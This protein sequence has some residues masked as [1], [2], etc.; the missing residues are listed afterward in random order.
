MRTLLAVGLGCLLDLLLGDPLWMPH[1]VRWIGRWIAWMEQVLRRRFPDTPEGLRMAGGFLAVG[2]VLPAG[3]VCWGTLLLADGIHPLAGL[4]LEAWICCQCLAARSL[5]REAQNV[6]S[7]L[8]YRGLLAARQAVA[9]IVGRDTQNLDEA[10]VIRA[11]VET[12]AENTSDGVVAPLFWLMVGGA[13]LGLCYKAVNT[14]DSMVGYRNERYLDFGRCSARLDDLVN[15]I[16]ARLSAL[17]MIL[18]AFLL[19]QDGK[20]AAAVWRRDR[21]K[22]P[23]PNSAQTESACAGALGVQLAGPSYYGGIL[24][25]KPT[26]GAPCRPIQPE[27]IRLAVRL[28]WGTALLALAAFAGVRLLWIWMV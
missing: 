9:R 28:M 22:H 19:G 24:H 15:W 12:V 14:L 7:A 6:L 21:R 27:D 5:G 25:Q 3:L 13:P 16:P 1:P 10:G 8:K 18:A 17:F 23:S 4:L 26:L 11:A 20:R 2:T